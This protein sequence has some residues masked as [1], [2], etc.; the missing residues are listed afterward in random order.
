MNFALQS[1][2]VTESHMFPP[3]SSL[4]RGIH[5]GGPGP[6]ELR[7]MSLAFRRAD[8]D[9][10]PWHSEFSRGFKPSQIVIFPHLLGE[11]CEIF[12]QLYSLSSSSSALPDLNCKCQNSKLR[13]TVFPADRMS[14][15]ISDRMLWWGSL[16]VRNWKILK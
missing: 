1:L 10:A 6:A 14:E 11:G 5:Q 15:I 4:P 13:I 8:A 7:A 3:R 9:H 2:A 12:C 16:E